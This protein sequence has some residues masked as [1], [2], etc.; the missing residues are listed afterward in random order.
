MARPSPTPSGAP[1]IRR[2]IGALVLALAVIVLS[3]GLRLYALRSDPYPRLDWSAGLLT[4]EGFYIHNARNVALFG[5][6]VTDEFNNMLLA[7]LLHG[8][9]V[10][11]FRTLGTGAVQARLISVL[12]SLGAIALLWSALRRIYGRR[13]AWIAACVLGLDHTNLLF[14]RM[15]LMDPFAAFCA[16]LAFW[17]FVSAQSRSKAWMHVASGFALGATLLNRSICIYLLPAPFVALA[18]IRAGRGSHAAI[19]CGLTLAGLIWLIGWWAPNRAEIARVS[20]YYRVEQVQPRSLQHLVNNL[21]RGP[22]GDHRGISPYLFRHTPAIFG[23][24]LLFLCAGMAPAA[25]ATRPAT[26]NEEIGAERAATAYLASWLVGGWLVLSASAYSPSRY[27]VTTY[28]AMTALAAISLNRLP[29]M[30]ARIGTDM[31]AAR[32]LRGA[33]AAFLTFHAIQSV[34]HRGGVVGPE[35]TAAL[36]YGV[37]LA[38]GVTVAWLRGPWIRFGA[39]LSVAAPI[40]WI[41]TNG[42]WLTDWLRTL[43]FTQHAVSTELGRILPRSSVL[44]GD[45]APGVSMDNRFMAVNVIPGLCNGDRPVERFAGR[46]RYIV[47]LDGRWKEAYWLAHYP[48]LVDA[49]RR[50]ML[51]RVLRWD[52][53]VYRVPDGFQHARTMSRIV[54]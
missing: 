41:A 43:R 46:P 42:Y 14:S 35:V 45:V 32:V 48:D 44:I 3:V 8:V 11:V 53:G 38:A 19:A 30:I 36:L 1:P 47:I 49:E 23:L 26:H 22:F 31:T 17:L 33:L 4:D 13:V 24:T 40:V 51:R 2:S 6:A 25:A 27:Y 29:E 52:V 5:R 15:A 37:P 9:Q 34:V 10:I 28:P 50:V 18:L 20:R 7:P 16:V 39:A 54:N 12:C 21:Y